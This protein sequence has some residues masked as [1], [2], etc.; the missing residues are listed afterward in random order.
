[1]AEPLARAE[2]VG[3][4]TRVS[5]LAAY[6][7]RFAAATRESAGAVGLAELSFL[8]HLDLRVDPTSRAVDEIGQALGVPLTLSPGTSTSAGDLTVVWL[9]PDEWLVLAPPGQAAP[10]EERVRAAAGGGHVAVVDVSAQRTTVLVSGTRAR[11]VLAHG[12]AIDLH[13]REFGTGA[14][15]STLLAR[16]QVV[17]VAHD[18]DVPA[19]WLLVRSTFAAYLGDW[20]LDAAT[21]YVVGEHT[22]G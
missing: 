21:E 17:L 9:G 3:R 18:V 8:T 19:Y 16:T 22:A 15:A 4:E 1:M 14:S 6:E 20:L 7:S 2:R 11:D 10:L 13:P 5:P 12:C